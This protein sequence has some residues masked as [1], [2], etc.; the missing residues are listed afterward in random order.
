MIDKAFRLWVGIDGSR[1]E[2]CMDKAAGK[3]Q[4]R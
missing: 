1:V 3:L 4:F 2:R